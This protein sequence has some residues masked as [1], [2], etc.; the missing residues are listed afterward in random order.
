ML[1]LNS[2]MNSDPGGHPSSREGAAGPSSRERD[3]R[4]CSS[5]HRAT[6]ESRQILRIARGSSGPSFRPRSSSWGDGWSRKPRDFAEVY[7]SSTDVDVKRRILRA[8][9][10]RV[11]SGCSRRVRANG[12][13]V[14][15]RSSS[16]ASWVHDELW[17]LYQKESSVDV[18]KRSFRR[19]SSATRPAHR[20]RQV[21]EGSEQRHRRAEPRADG[22]SADA[23]A[24]LD[25]YSTDKDPAEEEC[26]QFALHS[27]Q[28]DCA[29]RSRAQRDRP[30][31]EEVHR[32]S[33]R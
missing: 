15:R 19:C 6:L 5:S 29:R 17:Q 1:A 14:R 32:R 25:I 30:R 11:K 27:R 22:R 10:V 8:F 13:C 21:R 31:H 3:R 20:P 9:M 2:V 12:I 23:Q 7:T 18:K 4:R 16:S 33:C 24:L 28:R 26:D